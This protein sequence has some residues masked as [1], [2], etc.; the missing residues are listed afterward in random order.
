M[1]HAL[2]GLV[3]VLALAS[4]APAEA[5][6]P[7]GWPIRPSQPAAKPAK[8]PAKKPARPAKP[9]AKKVRCSATG[10][11]VWP[12]VPLK[13]PPKVRAMH[14]S[15]LSAAADCDYARLER[16]AVAGRPKFDFTFG[17]A[18]RPGAFWRG[19][20][21]KGDPFLRRMIQI[22]KLDYRRDG[23]VY[24]WPAAFA[25][26]ATDEDWEKLIPLFG[27]KEMVVFRD[28]GGYTGIRLA[29]HEDGDWLYC[30]EGD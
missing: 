19:L 13:A 26:S 3:A 9:A 17:D 25:R 18:K 6:N 1:R 20:E 14:Q 23:K 22:M 10:I 29:I 30:I 12:I 27:E 5:G 28:Y 8:K 2:I 4:A 16:L 11:P 24:V 7:P 15:I 21:A